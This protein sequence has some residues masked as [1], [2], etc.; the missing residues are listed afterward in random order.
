VRDQR[1]VNAVITATLG[2]SSRIANMTVLQRP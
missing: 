1:S 2:T